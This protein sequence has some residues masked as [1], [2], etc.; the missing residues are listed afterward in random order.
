MID[1][2]YNHFSAGEGIRMAG[3]TDPQ[4]GVRFV[5]LSHP[6]G[7]G[8]PIVPGD[9]DVHVERSVYHA[10][11]GVLSQKIVANMHVTTHVNAPIHLVQA[12]LGHRSVATT[13]RYLHARPG[14][15]SAGHIAI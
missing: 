13:S 6:F 3:V 10:R 7:H 12:T 15:S 14:E 2:D 9:A 4:T 8:A 11:D 5:E 1:F